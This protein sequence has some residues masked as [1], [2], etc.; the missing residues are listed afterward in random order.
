MTEGDA[1]RKSDGRRG[2]KPA[3]GVKVPKNVSPLITELFREINRKQVRVLDLEARSG[4][5]RKVVDRWRRTHSPRLE[6]L[7]AVGGVLGL[8]LVWRKKEE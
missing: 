6:T 8:E 7:A 1:T 4:V 3:Y 2:P 5:S